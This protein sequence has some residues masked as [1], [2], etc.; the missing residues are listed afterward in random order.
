MLDRKL[1][2]TLAVSSLAALSASAPPARAA[3]LY[4]VSGDGSGTPETLFTLNQDTGAASVA[5][6]LGNGG[7]FYQVAASGVFFLIG[8]AVKMRGLAA[9]G[10][11]LLGAGFTRC[12]CRAASSRSAPAAAERSGACSPP[13]G[14]SP[15]DR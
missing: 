13:S 6:A 10:L 7:G 4:G 2:L 15:S 8:S 5:T 14:A 1:L 3:V 12:R 9:L 11:G